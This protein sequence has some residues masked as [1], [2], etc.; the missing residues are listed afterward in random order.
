MDSERDNSLNVPDQ[1][2]IREA[3]AEERQRE[4]DNAG[5]I[6][7]EDIRRARRNA[8]RRERD[9]IRRSLGLV[10]VRGA[11]GGVYWE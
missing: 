2:D 3:D 11:L 5:D 4:R 7:A 1:Q 6:P 9:D 10:K 8:R